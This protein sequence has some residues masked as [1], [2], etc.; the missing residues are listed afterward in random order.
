MVIRSRKSKKDRQC[1]GRMKK[2]NDKQWYRTPHRKNQRLNN[3][4]HIKNR[5][6]TQML[7][8]G[9][10]FPLQTWQPLWNYW[11]IGFYVFYAYLSQICW[12]LWLS[13]LQFYTIVI[14]NYICYQHI[15]I[16][17]YKFICTF[18]LWTAFIDIHF[19]TKKIWKDCFV[20]NFK[21]TKCVQIRWYFDFILT[22][23]SSVWFL[24]S[25][26]VCVYGV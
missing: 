3:T 16:W 7:R 12:T 24:G 6:W 2:Y 18:C 8:K 17:L 22:S 15:H 1:N 10:Q 25:A 26:W 5:E 11:S 23:F 13:N 21:R 19:D 9:N 14:H 4:N 20:S